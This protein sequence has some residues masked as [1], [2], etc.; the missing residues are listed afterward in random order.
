MY[1]SATSGGG[2]RSSRFFRPLTRCARYASYVY[3]SRFFRPLTRCTSLTIRKGMTLIPHHYSPNACEFTCP[4]CTGQCVVR[5]TRFPQICWIL[6]I[7][8]KIPMRLPCPIRIVMPDYWRQSDIT[9][10]CYAHCSITDNP[11]YAIRSIMIPMSHDVRLATA[12]RP[13]HSHQLGRVG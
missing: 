7:F 2:K 5:E 6:G 13:H 4:L 12:Q 3:I 11:F 1:I 10:V 9:S 8:S